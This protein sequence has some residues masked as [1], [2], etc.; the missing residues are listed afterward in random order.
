MTIGRGGR[1]ESRPYTWAAYIRADCAGFQGSFNTAGSGRRLRLVCLAA[2]LLRA[3]HPEFGR[4]EGSAAL[5]R[6]ERRALGSRSGK[7]WQ[8]AFSV[9]VAGAMNRAPTGDWSPGKG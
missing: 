7:P 2:E 3:H 4:L 1:D 5:Y 9:K 8:S 6:R